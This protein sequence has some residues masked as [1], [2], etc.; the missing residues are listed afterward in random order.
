[1]II[2]AVVVITSGGSGKSSPPPPA[3]LPALVQSYGSPSIGVSGKL[4]ADWSAIRGGGFVRL[5][6][7]A[8]T[9]L[10]VIAAPDT[11]SSAH[12]LLRSALASM[13]KTYRNVTVKP[14]PGKSMGGLPATSEVVYT[15][16]QRGIPIRVLLAA[17]RGPRLRYLLEAFTSQHAPLNDL[18]ETQQIVLTLKLA[19]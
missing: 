19:G 8:G 10:I 13:Q 18:V 14:A 3:K 5:A 4:P 15:T 16:N 1:M 9:A 11:H 12:A 2:I 7:R 17:A 6:N